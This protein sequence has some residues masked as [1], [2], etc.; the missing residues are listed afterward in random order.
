[1][2]TSVKGREPLVT[3]L[4]LD[5]R[6]DRVMWGSC[7]TAPHSQHFST[8][9]PPQVY[10]TKCLGR[11]S[12]TS[13][14]CWTHSGTRGS[15]REPFR[16]VRHVGYRRG[17]AAGHPAGPAVSAPTDVLAGAAAPAPAH[18]RAAGPQEGLPQ[19]PWGSRPRPPFSFCSALTEHKTKPPLPP[20]AR[21]TCKTAG[22]ARTRSSAPEY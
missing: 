1:M 4:Q 20:T 16:T 8:R 13:V 19:A 7:L 3:A 14:R 22:R 11:K 18:C 12:N 9:T 6:T 15:H 2:T 5:K 10:R 21:Q 17:G